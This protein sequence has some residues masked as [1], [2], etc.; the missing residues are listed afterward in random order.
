[1]AE[2]IALLLTLMGANQEDH[3]M[4]LQKVLGNIWPKVAAT[5]PESVGAAAILA[6]GV[7]PEDVYN[8]PIMNQQTFRICLQ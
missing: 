6:L 8:L 1:M 4:F 5:T 2:F 7:T 3:S